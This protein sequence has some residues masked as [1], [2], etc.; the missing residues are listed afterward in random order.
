MHI[1]TDDKNL[2]VFLNSKGKV[3]LAINSDGDDYD[4][5]YICFDKDDAMNLANELLRIVKEEMQ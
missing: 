3:F 4:E 2:R 1:V 5:E